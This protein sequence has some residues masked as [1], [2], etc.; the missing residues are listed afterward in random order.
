[1]AII[2]IDKFTREL[3]LEVLYDGGRQEIEILTANLNRP[4]LQLAGYFDYFA[5]DRIQVIGKVEMTYITETMDSGK[6]Q[7]VFERFFSYEIPCV[8]ISRNLEPPEELL[9]AARR[10]GRPVLRSRLVTTKL[11]HDTVSYLDL[12]LALRVTR[13]GALI[14]VGGVGMLLVGESG[15]GKSETALELVKRGHRLVA[16]DVVEI[17]RISKD[18]LRGRSP[19]SIQNF[20]EIRGVGIINIQQMYGID[21]VIAQKNINLVI[22]L[23]N[24]DN[25]KQYDRLGLNEEWATVLGVKLRKLTVPVRPGRNLAIIMEVAAH[26][27]RLKNMG[28]NAAMELDRRVRESDEFELM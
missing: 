14:D 5:A 15:I 23:E 11:V 3:E 21:S 26:N 2:A 9:E 13:P 6:R 27:Y 24:W 4:G 8:I 10:Y 16:D 7:E 19:G 22:E 28:Y 17:C 18:Q 12:L 25:S 20:M 1:M